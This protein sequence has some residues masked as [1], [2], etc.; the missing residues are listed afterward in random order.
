MEEKGLDKTLPPQH[1]QTKHSIPPKIT[2]KNILFA[3]PFVMLFTS[4]MLEISCVRFNLENTARS[5][6]ACGKVL[7]GS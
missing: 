1:S 3:S 7:N 2:S 4:S 5:S 6:P